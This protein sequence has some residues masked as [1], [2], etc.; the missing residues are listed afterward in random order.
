MSILSEYPN[1]V[2]QLCIPYAHSICASHVYCDNTYARDHMNK[3]HGLLH[4]ECHSI[5]ICNLDIPYHIYI[6]S[7]SCG[8]VL[9][10]VA[11][12]CSVLQ[13]VAVCCSL[14]C[15]LDI[16][17]HIYIRSVSCGSFLQCVAACC[18]VLQCVA[19]CCSLIS[20]LDIPRFNGTGKRDHQRQKR[21]RELKL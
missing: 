18:S 8:S 19:V 14:I 17:Y 10:C 9:Q 21:R 7:V 16:P 20:N 1:G 13:C 12:C 15:N 4:L 2:S 6:R 3:I 5:S 11:V